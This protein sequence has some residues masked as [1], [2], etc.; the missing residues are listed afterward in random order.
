M[1]DPRQHFPGI[2]AKLTQLRQQRSPIHARIDLDTYADEPLFQGLIAVETLDA[3][4]FASAPPPDG[5]G[6]V[7]NEG[8]TI[9]TKLPQSRAGSEVGSHAT[10]V[11]DRTVT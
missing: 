11:T 5:C 7:E 8:A 2:L 4:L 6:E 1:Y 3:M 10:I 9:E